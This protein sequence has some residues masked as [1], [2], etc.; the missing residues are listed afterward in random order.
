MTESGSDTQTIEPGSGE[1]KDKAARWTAC[2]AILIALISAAPSIYVAA[3]TISADTTRSATEF[4]REQRTQAYPE[5]VDLERNLAVTER[6]YIVLL[7]DG[8]GGIEEAESRIDELCKDLSRSGASVRLVGSEQAG[9]RAMR[10]L[11]AHSLGT[12]DS[13]CRRGN[14]RDT[15]NETTAAELVVPDHIG[16]PTPEEAEFLIE[17]AM[18]SFLAQARL[19]LGTA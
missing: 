1:Q 18:D 14:T 17:Q 16:G 4:K 12:F 3:A 10:V 9:E 5:F 19:D 6:S 2:I 7:R 11:E 13:S 15:V 8:L